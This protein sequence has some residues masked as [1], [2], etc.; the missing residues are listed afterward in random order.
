MSK[1]LSPATILAIR[2]LQLA[3]RTVVD[4]FLTGMH[5]SR[6]KGVGLEFSQ[7][8]SYQPSDDLRWLDWKMYARSDRYYV[9]QS[10][11]ETSI[12]IQVVIDA[13]N[14]ML[15]TE[16]GISKIDYA[17]YLAASL[18]YLTH[19]QGDATALSAISNGD[20]TTLA[21]RRE[22]R[23]MARFYYQLEQLHAGGRLPEQ[24]NITSFTTGPHKRRLMVFITDFYEHNAEVMRLLDAF[25]AMGHEVIAFHLTG[26]QEQSARFSGY[27][28]VE[29]LET[30]EVLQL[31]GNVDATQYT[32]AWQAFT[33]NI[34]RHLMENNIH[35]R[36]LSLQAPMDMA[37]RDFLLHYSK[38]RR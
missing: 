26:Q 5:A 28:A 36:M 19:L 13:S 21:A 20:I 2:D 25:A 7:Y 15:H 16:E 11:I 17:R 12:D 31:D 4:G 30:G 18:G 32:Q 3:A 33:V 24:A 27:Q 10:E 14:S 23:H 8:R 34:H 37:L 35:Y 38:I 6:M 22:A 29:D 9:R 1:L